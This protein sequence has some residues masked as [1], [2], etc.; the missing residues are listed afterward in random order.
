MTGV[1][2][3]TANWTDKGF[4]NRS[5]VWRRSVQDRGIGVRPHQD[6]TKDG[7]LK[8]G[9]RR[10]IHYRRGYMSTRRRTEWWKQRTE[11]GRGLRRG[12]KGEKNR[13][14]V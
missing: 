3:R 6:R 13:V 10:G 9:K 2:D 4:E 12:K 14:V 11:Q 1:K 7:R 8:T 5:E